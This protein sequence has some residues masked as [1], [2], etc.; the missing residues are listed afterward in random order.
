MRSLEEKMAY[1]GY[2]M[3]ATRKA[4]QAVLSQIPDEIRN[5][6][7]TIG[8]YG[9]GPGTSF[10]AMLP[11]FPNLTTLTLVE[12]DIELMRI[13]QRLMQHAGPELT[14]VCRWK[15][16]DFTEEKSFERHDLTLFSYSFFEQMKD[17]DKTTLKHV[18][19]HNSSYIAIIEAGTPFAYQR[20]MQVRDDLIGAGLSV[21]APCPHDATCPLQAGDWC[22]FSTRVARSSRLKTLKGATMGYEDEKFS[23]LIM[24]RTP[25][26]KRAP[27]VLSNP[28]V[29]KEKIVVNLCASQGATELVVMKRDKENYKKAKKLENGDLFNS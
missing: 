15:E 20:L 24:G 1:I 14:G 29:F 22:H 16:A 8:D 2:R 4:V 12:K 28:Q 18:L 23:Y 9:A 5:C 21:I 25:L 3:P 19:S 27:R 26:A 11:Y 7:Q 6:I 13:G 10:W 17:Q